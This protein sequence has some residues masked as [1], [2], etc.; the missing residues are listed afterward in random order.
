MA[1]D[2]DNSRDIDMAV[3]NLGAADQILSNMRD[4]SFSDVAMKAGLAEAGSA[5]LNVGDVNRDSLMD[6]VLPG[7]E[8]SDSTVAVNQPDNRFEKV[9]LGS[10]I[11]S[12]APVTYHNSALLDYDNDGDQ[13]VLL[14]GSDIFGKGN[15]AGNSVKLLENRKESFFD[16]TEAVGLGS[17]ESLPVRGVSVADYDN[18]GD[19]DFA[20]NVN[21]GK[22]LLFRNKGGNQNQ[23]VQVQLV[24]S[25]SN[26]AGIGT[27]V[28]ILAGRLRQ[29]VEL[30]AGHG[31]LSQSPPVAHFGLGQNRSLDV[32]R[33]LWPGGVLQSEIDPQMNQRLS[34]TELDRKGTSCPI[35]YVWDGTN[36][37]FQTDFLGGSAFGALVSP[38]QFNYPDTDEY[39]KLDRKALRLKDG[40]V[41]VTL[42]NQLEEV[43]FFDQLQL[44]AVDHPGDYDVYPDEK[45][46]PGPPYDDF[47]LFTVSNPQLPIAASD[48]EGQNVLPEISHI[49]RDYP[50]G[51]GKLRFKGYSELHELEMDLGNVDPERVILIMHAWIDYADS[52]SNLAASQAGVKL[53]PPYLQVQD[54]SGEWVTVVDRMGFPAGL[55]KPMTVDLS[56]KFLSS[57][58]KIRI[59]TN[60]RI[61][62]DQILVES[63]QPRM[64]YQLHKLP[65]ANA[66][67]HFRGFPKFVSPDGRMPK[68]Y[69]YNRIQPAA[70]WKTHIGGYTRFGDV[71]PL[72]DSIDDQFVITRAGDEVEALFDVQSLP[73]LPEGWVRDYLVFVDGF[74][75]DMDVNSAAPDYVGPLPFHHMSSYPYPA[76]EIYPRSKETKDYLRTWN[77]RI[78]DQ[79]VPELRKKAA[80]GAV[81]NVAL[82]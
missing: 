28:E 14:A 64:D 77:T 56:G 52:T 50:E 1:T 27:K 53:V 5:D 42:N 79:W 30:A 2:F 13:D 71:V 81:E 57:S 55:P 3:A 6:F 74:G 68:V 41:A 39:I 24:G 29:K 73:P 19:V 15:T 69:D 80:V 16:V 62:W 40:Y 67:L 72:L 78:V 8:A 22:A 18:D 54:A 36:Y 4:G 7:R 49:D 76:G 20:L 37:R 82:P 66:D 43:I 45:L 23:W 44:V 75:K 34:I 9:V 35:L 59:V 63:G 10:E 60:M 47:R 12:S 31:F 65:V 32:V 61:F 21:G 38:G 58:R 46:L 11:W 70:Q 17:V 25:S 51:F 33:M 48:S 26:F